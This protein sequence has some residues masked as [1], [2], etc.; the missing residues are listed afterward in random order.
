MNK[1]KRLSLVLLLLSIVSC[2]IAWN[3]GDGWT[4]SKWTIGK[5]HWGSS[6][7]WKTPTDIS[8]AEASALIDLYDATDGDN[9]TNGAQG[10]GADAWGDSATANDW[11]GCTVV[12]GHLTGLSLPNN[13]LSGNAGSTVPTTVETLDLGQNTGLTDIDVS[14][15]TSAD[16]IDLAGCGFGQSVVSGILADVVTAAVSGG[17]LDIGGS[18]SA[19]TPGGVTALQ[20]LEDD[21]WTLTY[22]TVVRENTGDFYVITKAG[23][24]KFRSSAT[25]LSG[26]T[27]KY[28]VIKDS[29]GKYAE[30]YIDAADSAEA[31]SSE[32]L[33]N[34]GGPFTFTGDDPDSW[35]TVESPPNAE[36]SE[37]GS[38]EG[39]GG[40][41]SGYINFYLASGGGAF[42]VYCRQSVLTTN[43]LYLISIVIDKKTDGGI[44]ISDGLNYIFSNPDVGTSTTTWNARGGYVWVQR[45]SSGDNDITITSISAKAYTH[46]G[47]DAVTLESDSG[48]S[49]GTFADIESGF[50]YNVVLVEVF[51]A[52]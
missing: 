21:S 6:S 45:Y 29:A 37:V 27:G 28:I 36:I 26:Q 24:A 3:Y 33:T 1:F 11:F 13:A 49:D 40:I 35:T 15:L 30:A 19:P 20:T 9:W 42:D 32:L 43:N 34:P 4:G 17:T 39:H 14:G 46:L 51:N 41:G 2:T 52:S 25:D 44:R 5:V 16:D 10:S 31:F 38:G 22:S 7:T 8:A 47:T 48:E 18:N 50:N 23:E 12:G